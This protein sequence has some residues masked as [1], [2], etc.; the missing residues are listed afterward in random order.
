M[1]L[2]KLDLDVVFFESAMSLQ[3]FP[4]MI[5]ECVPMPRE[6]GDL[7]PVYFKV[8]EKIQC[9]FIPGY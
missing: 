7:A 4:H 9:I 8:T 1:F 6:T 5:L 3:K 2:E